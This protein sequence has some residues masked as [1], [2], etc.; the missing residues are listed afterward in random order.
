[1]ADNE[2]L[3]MVRMAVLV[4]MILSGASLLV[5]FGAN[6][7]RA[8]GRA[9]PV[10]A[11]DIALTPEERALVGKGKIILRELA[12]PGQKGRTY[13]AVGLVQ[14]SL[15]EAVSV[16]TDFEHY[17][18]FMPNVSAVRVCDQVQPCSVIETS[19]RLP[20][21]IKKRYRL[22][23]T[24]ARVA[25]GF[26]LDWEKI[27]W[28]ELKPSQTVVDTSGYWLVRG[29]EDGGLIVVY[30]VYTDPG[31]VPLGLN[32]IARGLAKNKIPDGIVSLRK[33]IQ[34]VFHPGVK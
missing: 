6:P 30:H 31:H 34:S 18:E 29:F 3:S 7:V 9:G 12:S 22:R 28:P 33:R 13:E 14:G 16:L 15:D 21:G 2:G 8:A 5:L 27:A 32:G 19:L 10:Q 1:M 26:D 11:R 25:S 20:L 4:A 17:P 24:A 23:Y